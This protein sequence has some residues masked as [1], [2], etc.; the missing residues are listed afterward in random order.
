MS[1][2]APS[3]PLLPGSHLCQRFSVVRFDLKAMKGRRQLSAGHRLAERIE[4]TVY[5]TMLAVALLLS[6]GILLQIQRQACSAE[7]RGSRV[8]GG[9]DQE[10]EGG[11]VWRE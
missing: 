4:L 9:F 11:L 10:W 8:A 2:R 7:T 6:G 3:I 1:K 5:S